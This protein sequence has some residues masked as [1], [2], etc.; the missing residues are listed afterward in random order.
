MEQTSSAHAGYHPRPSERRRRR[1]AALSLGIGFVAL[2]VARSAQAS[3]ELDWR[4]PSECPSAEFVIAEVQKVV[5]R[6][7]QE[8]GR[9]WRAGA[10]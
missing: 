8:L 2:L 9:G 3:F 5:G 10:G 7:W 4:A 6:P 1:F